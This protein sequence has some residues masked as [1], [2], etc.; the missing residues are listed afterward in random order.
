[1]RERWEL[2]LGGEIHTGGESPLYIG[3][4]GSP[5]TFP[6]VVEATIREEHEIQPQM[7]CGRS[8]VDPL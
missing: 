1:M 3:R 2:W 4:S 5:T 8:V 7:E 6:M